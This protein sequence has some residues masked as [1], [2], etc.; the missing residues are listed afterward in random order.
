MIEIISGLPAN[1]VA[2][3]ATGRVT[4]AECEAVLLPAVA[5]A[6]KRH[7]QLRLYYELECRFPGAA[8]EDLDIAPLQLQ[9]WERVALVT[10]V[11]W[12]R[13]TVKALRFLIPAEIRVFPTAQ[14]YEGRDWIAAGLRGR[15]PAAQRAAESGV[16][17]SI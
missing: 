11:S 17:A 9:P 3:T 8:W 5:R 4:G 13:H 10:D 16:A 1:V 14:A 2:F 7:E 6:R 15:R 12:V